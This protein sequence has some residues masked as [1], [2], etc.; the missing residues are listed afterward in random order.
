MQISGTVTNSSGAALS[1]VALHVVYD[2]ESGS[3]RQSVPLSEVT[4]SSVC[5][6]ASLDSVVL[7]AVDFRPLDNAVRI[8]W[9]TLAEFNLDRFI[10]KRDNVVIGM[11]PATNTATAHDY[12]Y[13]DENVA[14]GTTH[15][16]ELW[17][18]EMDT[19]EQ[20]LASETVTPS[21][22]YAVVTEYALFQ[23]FPNPAEDTTTIAFDLVDA[24]YVA[25]KVFSMEGTEITTLADN[26]YA[27]GRHGM[28]FSV[29][30]L[31]NGLYRYRL[32][33][34]SPIF[35][36]EKILLKNTTDSEALRYVPGI[37]TTDN[38]GHFAFDAREGDTIAVY[39]SLA[40][41][42]GTAVLDRARIVALKSG[43]APAD[44][45]VSLAGNARHSLTFVLN[46][47]P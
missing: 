29:S 20:L 45:T 40:R 43:Y 5:H 47:L 10:I 34:G 22:W 9:R 3:V 46:A 7:V 11:I 18:R 36:D 25:L 31:A 39:D 23:N 44:T 24:N 28:H 8:S 15:I 12:S 41:S 1:G 14:N 19:S 27:S 16:Y 4:V 37:A 42:L 17:V 38:S 35:V 30:N 33:V 32:S 21:F 6:R 13:T 26:P 2:F